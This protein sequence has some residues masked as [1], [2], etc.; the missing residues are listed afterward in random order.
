MI[1]EHFKEQSGSLARPGISYRCCLKEVWS[2][3]SS[4]NL[5][6]VPRSWALRPLVLGTLDAIH[7]TK[8]WTQVPDLDP[9]CST[10]PARLGETEGIDAVTNFQ[11][12]HVKTDFKSLLFDSSTFLRCTEVRLGDGHI[13]DISSIVNM[14]WSL[15]C[16]C[17]SDLS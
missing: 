8:D 5:R 7:P 16:S 6:Y 2:S 1:E 10:Q 17:S 4:A 9:R 3:S 11:R 14:V 13:V 15:I 12:V